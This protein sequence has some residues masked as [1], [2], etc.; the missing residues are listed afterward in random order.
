MADA[1]QPK[2]RFAGDTSK[3]KPQV[4]LALGVKLAEIQEKT[5]CWVPFYLSAEQK[6]MLEKVCEA[7]STDSHKVKM[8]A[9][10]NGIFT[11]AFKTK[12]AEL[13]K[14]AATVIE[15]EV[16]IKTLS[17]LEKEEEKMMKRLEEMKKMIELKKTQK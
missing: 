6:S 4:A 2:E 14:E 3:A 8:I 13:E 11:E 12:T 10:L 17:D 16:K 7:R 15:K 1:T 9:V 5:A